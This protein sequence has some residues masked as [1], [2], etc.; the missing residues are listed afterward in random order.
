MAGLKS[1]NLDKW[2]DYFRTANSDIF[3]I[4]EYAIMV[5]ASDCP[6]EFRIRRDGIAETLF[7]CKLT[8]CFGCN[9]V[10]LAVPGGGGGE[11]DADGDE[12]CKSGFERD[13][14]DFEVAGGS[15]G[16]KVNSSGGG[17][18]DDD[19]GERNVNQVGN[20]SYDAA[21][22]LTDEIEEETQIFGEV[23]RI[24]EIVDNS[25][26]ET[27]S[28]LYESLRKLQLMALSVETLKATEIGKAVN[29]VRKH[30]STE[31]RHLARTLIEGWKD[32]VD[33]W[34]KATAPVVASEATPES[35]NPSVLDEE[36]GLPSPPLDD[37]AFLTTSMEL[38]QFF[39][40]MEDFGNPRNGGEFN[41]NRENGRKPPSENHH[42]IPRRKP[43]Q[44]QNEPAAT[45]PKEKKGEQM[46]K[47]EAIMKKQSSVM[48][49]N[50]PPIAESGPGRPVKLNMEQRAQSVTK[51]QQKPDKV[52]IPRRPLASQQDKSRCSDEAADQVKLEATKRKL[53][54]RY[55]QAENAKRQRTIQV[56]ELHDLPKQ[57]L[58]HKNPVM[59][60]GNNNQHNRQ[61]ANGRR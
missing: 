40:G 49:P 37:L 54:E 15:K 25:E 41:K 27:D 1:T 9:R 24:K 16:S 42:N 50:K 11:A 31:I 39:D 20:Y 43:Q 32:L 34:V 45:L 55:Q 44:L 52:T 57:G 5:A 29:S 38:S 2:R 53:Q 17:G 58:G 35:M 51:I 59:K 28:V 33:E 48:K 12:G 46:K 47:Q 13:G 56:M 30:A 23:M 18:D 10:E 22:A 60:R 19:Q 21:E 4:I 8:K 7:S 36:E 14:C 3:D 6:K 61:W 26:D